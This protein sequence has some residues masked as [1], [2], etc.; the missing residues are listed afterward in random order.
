ME[1][2]LFFKIITLNSVIKLQRLNTLRPTWI[3]GC[4]LKKK[5]KK[6]VITIAY[7]R[8]F[9][10]FCFLEHAHLI[11]RPSSIPIILLHLLAYR[12]TVGSLD[13]EKVLHAMFLP[14]IFLVGYFY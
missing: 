8:F 10:L 1:G 13:R 3:G 7:R 4:N 14:K 2:R 6:W 5:K 9:F 11:G 12:G